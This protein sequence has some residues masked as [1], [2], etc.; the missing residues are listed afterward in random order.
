MTQ[1]AVSATTMKLE[2]VVNVDTIRKLMK[3]PEHAH[4]MPDIG[5]QSKTKESVRNVLKAA[6]VVTTTTTV[7]LVIAAITV[8][9][10]ET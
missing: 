1:N 4:A 6:L 7:C 10:Y 9:A 8:I 5:G 2:A 3:S